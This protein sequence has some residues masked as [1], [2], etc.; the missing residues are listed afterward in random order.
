MPNIDGFAVKMR[1]RQISCEGTGSPL[2]ECFE[3]F[4]IGPAHP[5]I[6]PRHLHGQDVGQTVH[7]VHYLFF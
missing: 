5:M 3:P 7:K 4:P 6:A 1:E 2:N